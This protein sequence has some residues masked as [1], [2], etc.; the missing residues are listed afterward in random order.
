M[1]I[2]F[3]VMFITHTYSY[4]KV[5]M[6]P[7]WYSPSWY[8]STLDVW[9][10][11]AVSNWCTT[12][13]VVVSLNLP[14]GTTIN[15][16]GTSLHSCLCCFQLY[17]STCLHRTTLHVSTLML[18][19]LSRCPVI[20]GATNWDK[21]RSYDDTCI[22]KLFANGRW[23]NYGRNI[24]MGLISLYIGKNCSHMTGVRR[25]EV[26]ENRCYCS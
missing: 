5:C 9:R 20:G 1:Y 13:V 10:P 8:I 12:C 23:L 2:T 18:S 25:W 3:Y 26:T 19:Q 24:Q 6:C 7:V 11:L 16:Y 17:S 14:T 21:G 22:G 4:N 15:K